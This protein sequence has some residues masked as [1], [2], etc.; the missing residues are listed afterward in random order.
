MKTK[1]SIVLDTNI[2]I[3][4]IT[5]YPDQVGIVF[6]V[7]IFRAVYLLLLLCPAFGGLLHHGLF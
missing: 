5:V 3:Y 4:S 6:C 2:L 7:K 1:A